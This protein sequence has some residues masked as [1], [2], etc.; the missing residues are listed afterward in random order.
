MYFIPNVRSWVGDHVT[1][2]EI[3]FFPQRENRFVNATQKRAH[4]KSAKR[5]L[6][7]FRYIYMLSVESV[8]F[9]SNTP[10]LPPPLSI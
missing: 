7:S 10:T 2:I 1:R 4:Y 3:F 6:G 5:V 8:I 9:A